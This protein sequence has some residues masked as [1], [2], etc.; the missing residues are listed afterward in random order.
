MPD[1]TLKLTDEDQAVVEAFYDDFQKGMEE[2]VERAIVRLSNSIIMESDSKYH[3]FKLSLAEKKAEVM[4]LKTESKIPGNL[5]R[6]YKVKA[7]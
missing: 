6:T 4:K 7:E 2:I 1:V 3:P 5:K